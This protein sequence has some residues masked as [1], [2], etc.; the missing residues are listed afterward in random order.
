MLQ[1]VSKIMNVILIN[2]VWCGQLVTGP[3]LFVWEFLPIGVGHKDVLK[4]K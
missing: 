1:G 2:A 4:F 3:D